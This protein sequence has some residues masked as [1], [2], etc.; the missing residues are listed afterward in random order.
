MATASNVYETYKKQGVMTASPIE[1]VILLYDGCL[2]QLRAAKMCIL[3]KNYEDANQALQK[4][5]DIVT[6]L[7]SSLDCRI[8]LSRQLMQIYDY[9]TWKMREINASKQAEGIDEIS[10][11]L[12]ELKDAW[13]KIKASCSIAYS[14]EG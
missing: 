9:V 12:S 4:A 8:G 7:S 2:R 13:A 5:Q 6:E 3:N 11:L 10:G 14:Q 1:L